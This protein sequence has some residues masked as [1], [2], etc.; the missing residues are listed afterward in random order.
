M[1]ITIV[2]NSISNAILVFAVPETPLNKITLIENKT[3]A[4]VITYKRSIVSFINSIF[5]V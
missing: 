4:P 3:S 5:E 1:Y 2:I